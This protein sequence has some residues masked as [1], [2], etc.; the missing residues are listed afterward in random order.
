MVNPRDD[1]GVVDL[2]VPLA[3]R[4]DLLRVRASASARARG[5]VGLGVGLGL[6]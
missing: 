4:E 3:P 5:R 6:T 2:P 1:G